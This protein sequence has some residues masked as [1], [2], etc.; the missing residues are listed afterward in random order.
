MPQPLTTPRADH[1]AVPPMSHPSAHSDA[2]LGFALALAAAIVVAEYLA[3]RILAPTLPT[4]GSPTVNDMLLAAVCYG[5]LVTLTAP[6]SARS[7]AALGRTLLAVLTRAGSWLAWVG[8]L[9]FFLAVVFVAPVDA[10]LWGDVK[11]PSFTPQPSDTVLL[12]GLA[13]PLAIAALLVV[14]GVVIPLAE[15]RLWRGLIQP[16]LFSAWG[17]A[18]A[19]LVTAVLFSL[20]HVIV[21]ASLGRFVAITLGGLVLGYVA[22]RA[23]GAD[24]GR[25]GWQTS[26][27]S[28]VLANVAA[29][30]IG[31]AA[32]A[33]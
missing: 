18:P 10:S 31:L 20:K 21:D 13:T 32:G 6:P 12:A 15:E 33:L 28:H 30:C 22:H 29:T 16:R 14:N 25:R 17:L 1:G 2:T 3:R 19:L 23:G 26:A 4:I 9:A 8:G 11:L 27:V 7:P 24:G 5:L